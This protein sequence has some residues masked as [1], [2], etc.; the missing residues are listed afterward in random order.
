MMVNAFRFWCH[1]VL[2]LVYDDSL[3]YYELLCK[4]VKH[5]N[6][7]GEEVNKLQTGLVELKEYV[8]KYFDDLD[9]ETL[10]QEKLDAAVSDLMS[11]GAID[12]IVRQTVESNTLVPTQYCGDIIQTTQYQCSAGIVVPELGMAYILFCPTKKYAT[13]NNTDN[14]VLYAVDLLTNTVAT[15]YTVK[16]G[17]G[18]SM[19]YDP[20]S[21]KLYIAPIYTYT[22]GSQV[23]VQKLYTYTLSKTTGI[24]DTSSYAEVNTPATIFGVSFNHST[25]ADRGVYFIDYNYQIYRVTGSSSY[26]TWYNPLDLNQNKD[27]APNTAD[28]PQG[29][30]VNGSRFYVTSARG[31]MYVFNIK[32]VIGELPIKR[33]ESK[34]M[35]NT[36]VASL[37][38]FGE[39]Q[40]IEFGEND[41]LYGAASLILCGGNDTGWIDGFLVRHLIDGIPREIS[42]NRVVPFY[43]QYGY[44]NNTYFINSTT[45]ANFRNNITE[46]KHPAQMNQFAH[47]NVTNLEIGTTTD[48]G[49]IVFNYPTFITVKANSVFH[50][51]K[52]IAQNGAVG[53]IA[54]EN[55]ALVINGTAEDAFAVGRNGAFTFAGSSIPITIPDG[56]TYSD[57]NVNVALTKPLIVVREVPTLANGG[58][59]K[60]GGEAVSTAGLYFGAS[61]LALAAEL[62][63]AT[64]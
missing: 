23:S 49:E 21:E 53:I 22:S 39:L 57:V 3:S 15:S 35:Q 32:L 25:S 38:L 33:V 2:P 11:S 55:A 47:F 14:G 30:A 17:H 45:E 58:D 18:N 8:D 19:C 9:V 27:F 34:F 6:D 54:G 13:D 46:L 10:L 41:N 1:K 29:F 44:T 20:D 16:C 40:D 36:D 24:L 12:D 61:R 5:M 31:K 62:P 50:F 59:F 63:P 56:A 64:P 43:T 51:T 52:I 60:V 4:V 42:A 28:A 26:S 7:I 48:F 37:R